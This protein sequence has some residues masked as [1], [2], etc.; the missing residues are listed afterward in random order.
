MDPQEP[1]ALQVELAA[2]ATEPWTPPAG[3]SVAACW[4][5]FGHGLTGRGGPGDPHGPA[6]SRG[7]QAR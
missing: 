3:P 5:G 6:R 2:S 1:M 7:A 4:V